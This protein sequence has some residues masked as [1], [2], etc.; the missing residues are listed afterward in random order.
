M[1]QFSAIL[2]KSCWGSLLMVLSHLHALS[3]RRL[4]RYIILYSPAIESFFDVNSPQRM[5]LHSSDAWVQHDKK[6]PSFC[7]S[8]IVQPFSL[9]GCPCCSLYVTMSTIQS[10]Q[11]KPHPEKKSF[12]CLLPNIW[13]SVKVN[14]IEDWYAEMKYQKQTLVYHVTRVVL[15]VILK[16]QIPVVTNFSI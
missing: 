14:I 1:M 12:K 10:G 6:L 11:V 16:Q 13:R 3:F 8:L 15:D 4:Y 9:L 7:F 2:S 5:I